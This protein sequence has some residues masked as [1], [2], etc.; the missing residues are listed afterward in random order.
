V[1][2]DSDSVV[3]GVE[4]VIDDVNDI[5]SVGAAASHA[6]FG[7]D[8]DAAV[9]DVVDGVAARDAGVDSISCS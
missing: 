4:I 3:N 5:D 2:R 8:H 6:P 7:V 1:I 9:L